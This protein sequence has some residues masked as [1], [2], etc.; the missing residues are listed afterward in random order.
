[1]DTD[2]RNV[3]HVLNRLAF[4]PAPGGLEQV[5]AAGLEAYLHSQLRPHTGRLPGELQTRLDALDTLRLSP[6]Q[7][8]EQ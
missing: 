7:L 2:T 4:G 1:M 5:K 6:V 3:L 8:F